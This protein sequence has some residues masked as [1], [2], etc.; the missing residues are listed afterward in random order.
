MFA[1]GDQVRRT[2]GSPNVNPYKT[3]I[4]LKKKTKQNLRYSVA[5]IGHNCSHNSQVFLIELHY[6]FS[7]TF[8]LGNLSGPPMSM[9]VSLYFSAHIQ[10]RLSLRRQL[11]STSEENDRVVFNGQ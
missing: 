1:A 4:N 7:S 3:E 9:M 5:R 10:N 6:Q 2:V 8:V 11:T